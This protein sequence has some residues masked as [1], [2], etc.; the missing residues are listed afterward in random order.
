MDVGRR[1]DVDAAVERP[2]E[3]MQLEL[4]AR[5]DAEVRARAA[6][7]PE[8]LRLLVGAR[9]ARVRPSAVTSSTARRLSIVSPNR[10]WSRPIAAAERQPGD[11][12]MPDDPDRADEAMLLALRCRA[13]RAALPPPQRASAPRGV[14]ARPRSAGRGR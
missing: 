8:Q 10:R 11:A 13:G 6:E 3:R 1:V 9:R 14:D 5:R 2:R 4:Q 7:A 12:G